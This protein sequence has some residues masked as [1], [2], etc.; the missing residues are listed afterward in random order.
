MKREM[1]SRER[2]I[3]TCAA[4]ILIKMENELW[5]EYVTDT[6]SKGYVKYHGKCKKCHD[7]ARRANEDIAWL[8]LHM[9]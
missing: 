7:K 3:L 8:I 6:N 5:H 9:E 4:N 1:T 2:E